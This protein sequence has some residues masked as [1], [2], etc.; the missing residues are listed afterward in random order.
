VLEIRSNT[1][2]EVE[3][4]AGSLKSLSERHNVPV[5]FTSSAGNVLFLGVKNSSRLESLAH[6]EDA[7]LTCLEARVHSDSVL[8]TLV[9]QGINSTPGV[10]ARAV[11]VLRNFPVVCIPD[12]ESG[13]KLSL[14]VPQAEM[15]KSIELLH[16][17]FFQHVDPT[18]FVESGAQQSGPQKAGECAVAANRTSGSQPQRLV[19]A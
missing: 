18:V 17:E 6:F 13:L 11:A 1:P 7:D 3:A 12:S 19:L 9:G 4:M 10:L 5:E 15:K 16:R 14:I 8:I 2:G